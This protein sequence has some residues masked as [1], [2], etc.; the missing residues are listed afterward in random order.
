M[1]EMK[2]RESSELTNYQNLWPSCSK[3][4]YDL[5]EVFTTHGKN[6]IQERAL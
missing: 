6:P 2:K 4:G 1:V 5:P 3:P